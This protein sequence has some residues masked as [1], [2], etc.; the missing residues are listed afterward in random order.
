MDP[1]R[2]LRNTAHL[3]DRTNAH[4]STRT[5]TMLLGVSQRMANKSVDWGLPAALSGQ[6]VW[7]GKNR[8]SSRS[9]TKGQCC[10]G[11]CLDT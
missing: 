3:Q 10:S 4:F 8:C 2:K 9:C 5:D 1:C 7:E 11:G 6:K